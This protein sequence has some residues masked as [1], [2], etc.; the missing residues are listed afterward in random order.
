MRYILRADGSYSVGTGHVMRLSAIAEELIARDRE[1]IFVGS[2]SGLKWVDERVRSLGF[3][4]IYNDPQEFMPNPGSD[5]LL[6]DSYTLDIDNSFIDPKKWKL[7]VAIVDEATP[8][9]KCDLRIHP[10]LDS[11]WVG[12]SQIP[13]LAGPKYLP[14]RKSL[15]PHLGRAGNAKQKILVVA[16]GSDPFNSVVEIATILKGF[17][18]PFEAYLFSD[19][20]LIEMFD[21]RF[22]KVKIGLQLDELIKEVDLVLTTSS[23][24]SLEFIA[25][26]LPVGVICSVE[27]QLHLYSSLG[28]LGLAVQIGFRNN[29][30]IW[31]FDSEAMRELITN[32]KLRESLAAKGRK[33]IDFSGAERIVDAIFCLQ[34]SPGE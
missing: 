12:E 34:R 13:I 17:A 31:T 6:L 32:P 5:V 25:C 29:M 21:N 26:G 11:L 22:H 3:S 16:G 9:Y 30:G 33:F 19:S 27:N 4:V 8:E 23:T 20:I 1:V 24:S 14:L 15:S 2:I 28:D 7:V 10:G 18:M